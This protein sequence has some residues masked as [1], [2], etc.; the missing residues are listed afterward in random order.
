MQAVSDYKKAYLF[1]RMEYTDQAL[2]PL[3][4]ERDE[5]AFEMV[6]KRYF[7]DLHAY[8]CSILRQAE[9][10]E[11]A[12]QQVF[13]RIW[14]KTDRIQIPGSLAAYLY[15]AV[16]NE[17][18]N[19]LKHQKVKQIHQTYTVYH[20]QNQHE[21]R[22]PMHLEELQE[23]IAGALEKLPEQCRTIFQMS[24]FEELRYREI[25]DRLGLSVKTIE[26]QMCK[27]LKLMREELAE[28][29]PAALLVILLNP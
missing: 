16:H 3:L 21:H 20:M 27:A 24:R 6:F 11:E 18:L 17:C 13:F 1:K 10:A 8:A 26:N 7:K 9:Q 15:R 4:L 28:Y 12:V 23:K 14:D 19:F 2:V 25:A 5:K 22:Q 29:L